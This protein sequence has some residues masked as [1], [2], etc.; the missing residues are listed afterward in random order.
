MSYG[1]QQVPLQVQVGDPTVHQPDNNITNLLGGQAG[2]AVI[3]RLHGEHFNQTVRGNVFIGSTSKDGV[4]VPIYNATG[5]TF[6][7]WNPAGSGKH[8]VPISI[9]FGMGTVGTKAV[10]GL[11]LSYKTGCGGAIGTGAPVSAFTHVAPVNALLGSGRNSSMLFAPA[12]ATIVAGALLLN[13]GLS[14]ETATAG[15]GLWVMQYN[16]KGSLIV[17]PGSLIHVTSAPI[18]CGSTYVI[19][20]LWEEV[21]D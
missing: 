17:T 11:G 19:T 5:A 15:N 14:V 12:A 21:P 1:I 16:F 3:S 10:S 7:L 20:L 18:A 9:A 4:A 8:C 6:A 13:F 2:E